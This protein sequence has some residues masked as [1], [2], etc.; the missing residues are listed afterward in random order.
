MRL[1]R[2][3]GIVRV[4]AIDPGAKTGIALFDSETCKAEFLHIVPNGLTGFQEWIEFSF[5]PFDYDVLVC[6]SFEMEE[7][8]HG[9][10]LTPMEIIGYLK[11]LGVPIVFQ[12]R[13]QRGKDKL[14]SVPVLKRADLY[15]PRGQVREGHQIA[16]LQHALSF[17]VRQRDINTIKLLHP[18][19]EVEP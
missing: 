8:T 18:R 17:L 3:W 16:A 1:E 19:E 15:P 14:I 9:I 12:R 7:G 10:D 5:F 2:G 6:E 13:M 11:G 4:L